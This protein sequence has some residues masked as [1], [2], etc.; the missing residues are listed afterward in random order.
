MGEMPC[1][2]HTEASVEL[3]LEGRSTQRTVGQHSATQ[4]GFTLQLLW[5]FLDFSAL[6]QICHPL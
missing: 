3:C 5:H 1:D 2:S 6:Q 4:T